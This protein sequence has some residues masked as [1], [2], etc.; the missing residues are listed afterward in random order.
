MDSDS[1]SEPR[2][3]GVRGGF[4]LVYGGSGD[5]NTAY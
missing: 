1:E 3:G 4:G 2:G 5:S